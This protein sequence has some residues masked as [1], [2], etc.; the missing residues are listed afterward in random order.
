VRIIHPQHPLAGQVVKVIRQASDPA[1]VEPNWIIEGPERRRL[2]VPSSWTAVVSET[3]PPEAGSVEPN[4]GGAWVDLAGLRRLADVVQYLQ[5]QLSKEVTAHE[6][7]C[8][9]PGPAGAHS[10]ADADERSAAPLVGVAVRPPPG[11]HQPAGQPLAAP[12][13]DPTEHVPGGAA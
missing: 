9:A 2:K 10:P 13:A 5:S 3:T 8:L 6:A 1:G 7:C 4:G 12:V 11:A